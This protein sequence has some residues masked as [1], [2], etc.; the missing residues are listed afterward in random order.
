MP[1]GERV[2]AFIRLLRI[3]LHVVHRRDR[4]I[5]GL[6]GSRTDKRAGIV[7]VLTDLETDTEALLEAA[8]I[9]QKRGAQTIIAQMAAA[10]RLSDDLELAYA[11]YQR[12]V[13]ILRDMQRLG[14]TVFD[15]RPKTLVEAIVQETSKSVA[16]TS[17]RR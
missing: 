8:S 17:V 15:L 3:R 5:Q 6:D 1:S 4:C 12:N 7:V 13:R 14:L 11:E 10:W 16:L 9:R 2:A